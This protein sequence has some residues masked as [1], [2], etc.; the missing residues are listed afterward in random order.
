MKLGD[1]S[2]GEN[3]GKLTVCPPDGEGVGLPP[4]RASNPVASTVPKVSADPASVTT[5]QVSED[6]DR[7]KRRMMLLQ[8]ATNTSPLG[9]TAIAVG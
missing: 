4:N 8:S 5:D 7:V 6:G 2:I 9:E 3:E 1:E